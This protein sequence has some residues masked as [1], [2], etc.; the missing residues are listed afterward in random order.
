MAT[1]TADL[2]L[3]DVIRSFKGLKKLADKAT[4]QVSDEAFFV[5]IDPVSNSLAVIYKHMGGNLRS[6]WTDF[7]TTDGEKP[8]RN[9]DSEFIVEP[10]ASRAAIVGIWEGGW[11]ILVDSLS[12]LT[13]DH[14]PQTV[15]IRS[16]PH[17]VLQAIDRSLTHA[18]YHVGQVVF[19]SR[20]LVGGR[21]QTLSIP[22]GESG[23]FNRQLKERLEKER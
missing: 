5:E 14:L 23:Q 21:W 4:A 12:L 9:R 22:R 7:L 1:N 19:L 8:D 17:S 16:E 11:Q 3:A 2:Y 20:H 6:R 18:A 15:L 13:P 10:G